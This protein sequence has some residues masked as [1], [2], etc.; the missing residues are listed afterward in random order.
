MRK[1]KQAATITVSIYNAMVKVIDAIKVFRQ[2]WKM[3]HFPAI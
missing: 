1:D 3:H 2:V